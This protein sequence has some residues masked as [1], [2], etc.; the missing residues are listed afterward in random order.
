MS[1]C[2]GDL[3]HT[4]LDEP[5]QVGVPSHFCVI[6]SII[7]GRS[8]CRGTSYDIFRY[9]FTKPVTENTMQE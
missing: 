8:F 5:H 4:A 3:Q 2:S 1:C 7:Y 9:R 6:K